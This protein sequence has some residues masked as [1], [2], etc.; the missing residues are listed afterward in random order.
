M[1]NDSKGTDGLWGLFAISSVAFLALMA[2]SPVKDYFREYRGHQNEYRSFLLD[3]AGSARELKEAKQ[4][5]VRVRQIWVPELG[6]AVDRCTSCHLGVSNPDAA[7]APQPLSLHPRTPHTPESF[8]RFGCVSCHRGQGRATTEEDA[9]GNTPDWPQPLL[10][11]RYT[12]A[13]CG[14]CHLDEVVPEAAQ[15]SRGRKLMLQSGCYACH[16]VDPPAVWSSDAPALDGL[17]QKTSPGWLR[18]WLTS[19][20]SVDQEAKMPDFGLTP[21]EVDSLTA[22]L[23]SLAPA[24][25]QLIEATP[26]ELAEGDPVRGKKLFR[27]SRCI[28]CHTVDG[29]GN[30]SGPELGGVGSKVNQRWLISFLG[31]PHTFQ[32]ATA[33]PRYAF[34]PE[35]LLDLSQY[36]IEELYDPEAPEPGEPPRLARKLVQGGSRLFARYGCG[37]CHAVRGM[38]KPTPS[39]PD[40]TGI[41]TK[42]AGL[43]DFG[44]RPDLSRSLPEGLRAKISEPR[45]FA[46]G[47]RMPRYDFEPDD[48]EAIVTA[49]LARET[50]PVPLSYRVE[51]E[52]VEYSPPGRFGTLADKYRCMSCHRIE[53]A[54]ADIAQAPLTVEGSRVQTEW[55][56]QYL[57]HPFTIR[58]ILTDR[59]VPLRM[60]D[61]EAGFMAS[62]MA[63]VYLDDTITDDIFP[64]GIDEARTERGRRLFFERYGCQACHMVEGRGGYYGPLMDNVGE[65]LKSG[66]I[67]WWLQGPQ[68]WKADV[69]CPNYGMPD[70]DPTDIAAYLMTLRP[71][72]DADP[73]TGNGGKGK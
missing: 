59:M 21:A 30:G 58:P 6:N 12:E 66:W 37:G 23:W 70:G 4:E 42:P 67:E 1:N 14:S 3:R 25:D 62:F 47:L 63:N 43:L 16:A 49:L 46:D 18:A 57:L 15:L 13:S 71:A 73:A 8:D 27:E 65:R 51:A 11:K 5:G 38:A 7:D 31:D 50:E 2:V 26:A 19:P 22:Y 28:S 39:G 36:L 40:L 72:T 44:E 64:D 55:M 32:P 54:G 33:M 52:A 60:S 9:H 53:G 10:P 68:R 56:K 35:D 34:A 69:R 45:S 20:V 61:E 48:V 41:G 29:R 17:S 24:P